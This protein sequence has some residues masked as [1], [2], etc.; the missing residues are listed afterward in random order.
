MD[1]V[2]LIII[3]VTPSDSSSETTEPI[4]ATCARSA[5]NIGP[6]RLA[7]AAMAS[8]SREVGESPYTLGRYSA[9]RWT[10]ARD[11]DPDASGLLARVVRTPFRH[12]VA[13]VPRRR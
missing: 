11:C 6:D 10:R 1:P 8:R 5:S 12:S 7:N 2:V 3:A 4:T 9:S 13:T